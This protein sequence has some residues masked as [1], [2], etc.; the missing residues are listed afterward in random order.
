[1][2]APLAVLGGSVLDP[3]TGTAR[4]ADLLLAG[5][6]VTRLTEPGELGVG[7]LDAT[8]LLVAPGLID[9]QVNGAAGVDLTA[10]PERLWE[11][12]AALPRHG[13]TSFLPTVVTTGPGTRRRALETLAAGRPA[14]VRPG[15]DP[16]GLHIEGPMLAPGRCGAHDPALLRLPGEALIAGWSAAAGVAMVTLAPEL[17]GALDVIRT[18]TARGVVVSLGHTAATLAQMEA[19]VAAGARAVT[20]LYNAMPGLG[21]REPGPVGAVLGGDTLVAG[22]IVDGHHIHPRT[23]AATWRAIGPER[24]WAVSDTT[25][26][27]DQP[28]GRGRLGGKTVLIGDG[29]VRL[30]DAPDT[31][32]GSAVGLDDCVRLLARFTGAPPALALAAATAVPARLVGRPDLGTLRVGAVA[33]IALFTPGLETV[34]TI[35]GGVLRYH[36]DGRP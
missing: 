10:T 35:A 15:A 24:F 32:A 31:L 17:P 7:G 9:L 2:T 29:T 13:V 12:A 34:A 4:R 3:A 18:L 6:R 22:G 14:D 26:A 16:L 27:L 8:G 20:H 23:V 30:A 11:V 25:A 19:A 36:R 5:G 1:V 33:D 28:P 21:H